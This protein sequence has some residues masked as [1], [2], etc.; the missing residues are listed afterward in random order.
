MR[1][2]YCDGEMDA[3]SIF[4]NISGI[5]WL[6]EGEEMPPFVWLN[7]SPSKRGGFWVVPQYEKA[8][9]R[10][11]AKYPMNRCKKCKILLSRFD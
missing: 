6:P 10:K 7:D 1:C 9:S 11:F 2:P 5:P 8:L 3:G 4:C